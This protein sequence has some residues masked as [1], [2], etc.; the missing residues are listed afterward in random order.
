MGA[1]RGTVAGTG[2]GGFAGLLVFLEE[3]TIDATTAEDI[4]V[5]DV[6]SGQE[7]EFN[8]TLE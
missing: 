6:E 5:V 2:N 4:D 1:V 3:Y 8:V 7:A